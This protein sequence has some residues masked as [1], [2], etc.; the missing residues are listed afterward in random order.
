MNN[1]KWFILGIIVF[2]A[3]LLFP[4][5]NIY[6]DGG[7]KTYTSLV[8]KVISWN[9][10][11]GKTGTEIKLFPNNFKPLGDYSDNP[12]I[13]KKSF[14]N[15]IKAISENEIS[16]NTL[17]PFSWD[18]LY[19]FA[20]YT[21]KE[22]M[23]SIIGFKSSEVKET[24]N[25]GMQQLLFVKNGKI[26]CSIVGYSENLGYAFDFGDIGSEYIMLE[27]EVDPTFNISKDKIVK[28]TYIAPKLT[29][30]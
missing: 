21:S 4:I 17:T 7:T 24:V 12:Q 29:Q 10:L 27:S 1:K 23:E 22:K 2:L 25:E 28:L 18:K 13:N 19:S 5:R 8:Y 26:V 3:V 9:T 30:A 16:L 14:E 6:K 15:N 11:E 20:P